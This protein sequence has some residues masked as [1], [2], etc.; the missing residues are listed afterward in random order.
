M[1]FRKKLPTWTFTC[2]VSRYRLHSTP[3]WPVLLCKILR[4]GNGR[5]QRILLRNA[6]Q[7]NALCNLPNCR[8]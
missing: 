4:L 7:Y 8:I 2:L 6:G 1:S 5:S 3:S